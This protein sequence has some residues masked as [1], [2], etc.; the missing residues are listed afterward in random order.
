MDH[1]EGLS[2][3]KEAKRYATELLQLK[4]ISHMVNGNKFNEQSYYM[5]G[6]EC[7]GSLS[8]E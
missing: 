4:F 8:P 7:A 2:D 6:Q 1:V 3:R 5:I